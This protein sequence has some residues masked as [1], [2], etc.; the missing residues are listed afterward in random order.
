VKFVVSGNRGCRASP[1]HAAG[2]GGVGSVRMRR[3][4]NTLYEPNIWVGSGCRESLPDPDRTRMCSGS[5]R[6]G[7]LRGEATSIDT[8]A[9]LPIRSEMLFP[10]HRATWRSDFAVSGSRSKQT[11]L[12]LV[13]AISACIGLVCGGRS[14]CAA[15]CHVPDRPV[16]GSS[17][18]WEEDSDLQ[19]KSVL[20][21]S[22]PPVLTHP[23]CSGEVPHLA[24]VSGDAPC[25]VL[26][27]RAEFAINEP[28][29]GLIRPRLRQQ[30]QPPSER[31]DRPPR[32]VEA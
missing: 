7:A 11:R 22:A 32:L 14:A 3:A 8:V 17:L 2:S 23:P 30:Q 24:G 29:D 15:G 20:V 13:L 27:A 6:Q 5:P 26:Q 9:F 21:V 12:L 31:L 10:P 4:L 19:L 1:S 28:S 16:L 18:S 25:A